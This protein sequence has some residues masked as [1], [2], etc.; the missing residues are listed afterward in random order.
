MA[1]ASRVVV[2]GVSLTAALA[3]VTVLALSDQREATAG[4]T[5]DVASPAVPIVEPVPVVPTTPP[6]TTPPPTT[7]VIVTHYVTAD[8]A[9]SGGR[10]P[11]RVVRPSP[12]DRRVAPSRWWIRLGGVASGSDRRSG[13]AGTP[14]APPATAP[15]GGPDQGQL[16]AMVVTTR[17]LRALGSE[18]RLTVV[19]GDH[20]DPDSA[21]GEAVSHLEHLEQSWSRFR[22]DSELSVLNRAGGVPVVVTEETFSVVAMAVQAGELTEGRFDVTV[23]DALEA[24]GYDRSFEFLDPVAD[25]GRRSRGRV[26]WV[27]GSCG[28]GSGSMPLLG[29]SPSR[30]GVRIDLGGIGKGRAADLVCD[31]LLGLGALGVCVDLGGDV[32]VA[33]SPPEGLAWPVS[34][35]D[36][37]GADVDL[38]VV[39]LLD[40]GVATSSRLRR[41]WSGADGREAHHLID[42]ATGRPARSDLVAVTV[43]AATTAWA[44]VYA[45][46]ALLA[47]SAEGVAMIAE[48]GLSALLVTA[49]GEVLTAGAI[50]RHLRPFASPDRLPS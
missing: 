3:M 36:P 37:A 7:I 24:A 46:A 29:P 28:N 35:A 25:P 20:D 5:V 45:K 14:S 2:A 30:E 27:L 21:F 41:R 10:S 13:D 18:C 4:A 48:A 38:A 15:A 1:V 16:T 42:P 49:D 11:R 40:G 47:G 31:R 32:R 23:L 50:D 33:G 12:R 44:D 39:D 6:P 43:L 26:W 9:S 22:P 19:V 8:S 17:A 34:V